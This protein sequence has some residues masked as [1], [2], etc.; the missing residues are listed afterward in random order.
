MTK[1]RSV[2]KTG[3]RHQGPGSRDAR[4][5]Q[6][7]LLPRIGGTREEIQRTLVET[8]EGILSGR[9]EPKEAYAIGRL[10]K[11][12]LRLLGFME[13]LERRMEKERRSKCLSVE[14][15]KCKRGSK[16]WVN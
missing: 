11:L 9:I 6:E 1:R 8:M 16:K 13:Q 12:Q 10:C 5:K 14:E 15:S 7:K 2:K 4:E 3:A